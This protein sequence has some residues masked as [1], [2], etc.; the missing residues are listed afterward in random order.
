MLTVSTAPSLVWRQRF[1]ARLRATRIGFVR[2]GS[3]LS[4]SDRLC[5]TRIGP[6]DGVRG[7]GRGEGEA[8]T[9]PLLAG[10]AGCAATAIFCP[11]ITKP[12]RRRP[13]A[14][15]RV[16]HAP[17]PRASPSTLRV[18][19][20]SARVSLPSAVAPAVPGCARAASATLQSA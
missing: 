5:P 4:D 9:R 2:L 20:S 10:A 18:S 12:A 8:P 7:A 13:C 19:S 16:T 11:L 6:E 15:I 14:M 3:A 17:D 1:A